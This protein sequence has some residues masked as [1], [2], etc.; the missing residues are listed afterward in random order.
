MTPTTPLV[1]RKASNSSPMTTI[2]FGV[3]SAS[4]NSFD[5]STGIQNRRSNSPMPVPALLSVRNLLSS[6]RSMG[7]LRIDYCFSPRL[8]QAERRVNVAASSYGG[9]A[10]RNPPS[11]AITADYTSLIRPTKLHRPLPFHR[12]PR[13]GA[14]VGPVVPHRPV[15][16]A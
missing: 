16:G 4:G 2:F 10:K 15:L 6:A 3:P 14:G 7:G 5:S 9:L 8:T 11:P 1:S 12:H 13:A